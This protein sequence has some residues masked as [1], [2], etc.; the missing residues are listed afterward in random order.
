[1]IAFTTTR[2][3]GQ[4]R[5]LSFRY[6]VNSGTP[7]L[8]AYHPGGSAGSAPG[9]P[10]TMSG[11]GTYSLYY[12]CTG[13]SSVNIYFDGQN[14][15]FDLQIDG[16][17]DELIAAAGLSTS[18]SATE[19]GST[20]HYT[21]ATPTI[22]PIAHAGL[23]N[24]NSNGTTYFEPVIADAGVYSTS[25]AIQLTDYPIASI[26]RLVKRVNGV[27][28]E[29]STSTAVIAGD[30]L[31]FTH[32]NLASGDLVMFT[33]NY[34]RESIGRSMTLTHYDSRFVVADTANGKVYTYKPVITNGVIASWTLTEV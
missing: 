25:I 24:S 17:K 20:V 32:P 15:T 5:K 19:L 27:D 28:V 6:K 26:E 23:L 8:T 7:V 21:L 3:S 29:L 12:I 11:S 2:A 33:Y 4:L 14:Y 30:G 9:M 22:T 34:N 10:F 16:V 31:S 13:T 18:T 1:M